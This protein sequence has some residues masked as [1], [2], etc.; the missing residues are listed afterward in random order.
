MQLVFFRHTLNI[1]VSSKG[2][3]IFL[4][5]EFLE[6]YWIIWKL[7]FPSNTFQISQFKALTKQKDSVPSLTRRLFTR[8]SL[9][10]KARLLKPCFEALVQNT[11]WSCCRKYGF[12]TCK[13]HE[14]RTQCIT[15]I[16]WSRDAYW[17]EWTCGVKRG[18]YSQHI[19]W[20]EVWK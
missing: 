8:E 20:H 10:R 18:S 14:A 6:I 1:L 17:L 19:T 5:V 2:F 3:Y 12:F 15:V 4:F 13:A 11:Q 16:I 7:A 9:F